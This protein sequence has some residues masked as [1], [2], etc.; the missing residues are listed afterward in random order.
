MVHFTQEVKYDIERWKS[1]GWEWRVIH[2]LLF[3]L[4][5]IDITKIE[6]NQII[7]SVVSTDDI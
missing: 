4:Y 7:S 5:G 6:F 2:K 1:Y 3:S